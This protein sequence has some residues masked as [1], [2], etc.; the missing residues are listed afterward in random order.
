MFLVVDLTITGSQKKV[1]R[2][3]PFFTLF[4]R[5]KLKKRWVQWER[6]GD[7]RGEGTVDR[8]WCG[9]ERRWQVGEGKIV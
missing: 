2:T 4:G 3:V 8:T 9:L 6:Y 1:Y 5:K 7:G